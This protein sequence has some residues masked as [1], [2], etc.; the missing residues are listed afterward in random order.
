MFAR[1]SA[2]RQHRA[3]TVARIRL[4]RA[5]TRKDVIVRSGQSVQHRLDFVGATDASKSRFSNGICCDTGPTSPSKT[6][7]NS[8][9]LTSHK[10]D[11]ET[12]VC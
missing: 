2:R 3:E 12:V 6:G 5:R 1:L 10:C 9:S 7:L 8:I 4:S 11:Q